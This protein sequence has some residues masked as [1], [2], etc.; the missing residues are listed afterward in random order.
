[1]ATLS[2]AKIKPGTTPELTV[3]VDKEDI[4]AATVYVTID[5]K[6]RQLTKTTKTGNGDIVLEPAYNEG[7]L[8]GTKVTVQYTQAETLFLRSGYASLEIGWVLED[9]TADKSDLARLK[10][11]KA[12]YRGVM[13]YG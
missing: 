9:G 11:P 10:I 1:M 5:M 13:Y 2:A 7:E 12:L 8:A 6:D 3:M 4:T